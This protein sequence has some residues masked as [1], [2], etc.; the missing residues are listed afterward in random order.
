[1]ATFT[2]QFPGSATLEETTRALRKA[3]QSR[4]ANLKSVEGVLNERPDGKNVKINV[5]TFEE[6]EFASDVRTDLVCIDV[7]AAAG[8]TEAAKTGG[9][10]KPVGGVDPF[11][12]F[13]NDKLTKVQIFSRK[14]P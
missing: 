3:Q 11:K 14:K 2:K 4:T 8:A 7:S 5:A 1:M 12:I 6:E 10:H 9:T 13:V